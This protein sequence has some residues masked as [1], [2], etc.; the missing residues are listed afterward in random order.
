MGAR[1][2][3]GRPRLPPAEHGPGRAA[4]SGVDAAPAPGVSSRLRKNPAAHPNHRASPSADRHRSRGR[5]ALRARARPGDG[6]EG[7]VRA[8]GSGA[9]AA[10]PCRIQPWERL[11]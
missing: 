2:G 8:T 10:H 11:P 7:R 9:H 3:A 1:G 6:R 5:F 4:A